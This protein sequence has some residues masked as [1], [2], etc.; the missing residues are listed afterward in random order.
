[1]SRERQEPSEMFIR[2]AIQRYLRR[3]RSDSTD[4]SVEAWKYRLKLFREW[5]YG[6]DLKR[7]GEL[8]GLDF[9]EYYEIRAGEVAP[10]TLEGEM[11]T[12]RMFVKYLEQIDAVER[13]LHES[14]RIP[15][16]D[17]DE[18]ASQEALDAEP[19]LALIEYFRNSD[20]DRAKRN[21]AF[22]ELAW[23]TGA[24]QSGL[25]SLDLRDVNY[26]LDSDEQSW[27]EF[28]NR[29]STGPRLKNG[30]RGERPVG[31][32]DETARV[33]SEYVRDYRMD[34]HDDE[35][36]QPLL[37]TREGRPAEATVRTWSYNA[38]LPCL[39]GAC[40]HGKEKETCEWTDYH[41]ASKCPSSR[42]PHP[43]RTGS[44]T[45]QL[46][47]GIPPEVVA[48]RVNATVSTIEDH[49][50]WASDE[51]RWQRYRDRLG[52]RREYVERLDSDWS[53]HDDDK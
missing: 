51:E 38:T 22:L 35:G 16:L 2:R 28:H 39:H 6:I 25:R 21:H 18:R 17:R 12:L 11:W 10:V 37:S 24:R 29:E 7:V 41:K 49:Y 40:P 5:C 26:R 47:I 50:D 23:Y 34:T 19:A 36:R 27:I 31:I 53:N 52:K 42:S 9:D 44:I 8:R 4:S 14:V 43:I 48:E 3:R 46:N 20:R 45:W 30:V 15:E 32:P 1:M 13:G 33:I